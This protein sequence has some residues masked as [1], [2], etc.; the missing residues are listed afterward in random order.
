MNELQKTQRDFIKEISTLATENPELDIKFCTSSDV[1]CED[2]E[3]TS[4]QI[5][6]VEVSYWYENNDGEIFID[7]DLIRDEIAY[8]NS[9]DENQ[10]DQLDQIFNDLA[11]KVICVWTH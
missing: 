1:L 11:K 7:Y 2:S 4:Q 5:S 9:L 6:K 3:W 8:A 10:E